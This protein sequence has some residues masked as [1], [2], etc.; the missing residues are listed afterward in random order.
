MR[1]KMVPRHSSVVPARQAM[2][3]KEQKDANRDDSLGQFCLHDHIDLGAN[4]GPTQST[5][6]R[7]PTHNHHADDWSVKLRL[8]TSRYGLYSD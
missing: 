2:V 3:A 1:S 6:T 4:L 5:I 7:N 8:L